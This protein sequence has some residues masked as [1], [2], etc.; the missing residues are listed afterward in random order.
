MQNLRM[1]QAI[2]IGIKSDFENYILAKKSD[3]NA[4]YKGT[5]LQN[6]PP[7][8]YARVDKAVRKE[9]NW[10]TKAEEWKYK[11]EVKLV[12]SYNRTNFT[13][14]F[15]LEIARPREVMCA[16]IRKNL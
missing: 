15:R 10:N 6:V 5:I 14:T 9:K 13:I 16:F 11:Q 3:S 12:S 8:L 2:W 7:Q 1:Y 4:S